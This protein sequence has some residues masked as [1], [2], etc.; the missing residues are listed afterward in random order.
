MSSLCCS[1]FIELARHPEVTD[2]MAAELEKAQLLQGGDLTTE[3]LAKLPYLQQVCKELLRFAPPYGGGF[4]Q[5]LKTFE[6]EVSY[7][8]IYSSLTRIAKPL[9]MRGDGKFCLAVASQLHVYRTK[10]L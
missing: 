6:L 3:K 5:V 7:F 2:K 8:D 10:I 9:S 1:T 4:R